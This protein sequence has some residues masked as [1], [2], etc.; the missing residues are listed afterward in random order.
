M[1]S[2]QNQEAFSSYC[3]FYEGGTWGSDKNIFHFQGSIYRQGPSLGPKS[4]PAD[5]LSA[6]PQARGWAFEAAHSTQTLKV[7]R[8]AAGLKIY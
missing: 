5:L 3:L 4:T 8:P 1:L 6:G 7:R 2:E